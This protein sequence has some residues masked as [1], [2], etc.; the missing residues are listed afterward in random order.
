MPPPRLTYQLANSCRHVDL[1]QPPLSK[2]S[3]EVRESISIRQHENT[4]LDVHGD[5]LADDPVNGR[6]HFG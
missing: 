4:E 5:G 6:S 2:R 1:E 3:A